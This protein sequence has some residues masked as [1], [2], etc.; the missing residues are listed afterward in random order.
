MASERAKYSVNCNCSAASF[1]LHFSNTG[2]KLGAANVVK[3][4]KI[5]NATI[6]SMVEKPNADAF[7]SFDFF[8]RKVCMIYLI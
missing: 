6:S 8:R 1:T 4:A 5:N 3:T 2:V 7:L